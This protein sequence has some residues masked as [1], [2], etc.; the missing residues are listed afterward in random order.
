MRRGFEDRAHGVEL[1]GEG[2][3][4]L[5]A[6]GDLDL[7]VVDE[8]CDLV[9]GR[10]A[11]GATPDREELDDLFAGQA[12][13]PC[14]CDEEELG[15]G[16]VVVLAVARAG[17]GGLGE[18]ADPLVVADRRDRYTNRVGE[19]GDAH[20]PTVNLV[21]GFKVKPLTLNPGAG[22]T[23][24]PRTETRSRPRRS[25]CEPPARPFPWATSTS[26][27]PSSAKAHRSSSYTAPL[28]WAAPTCGRSTLG[29]MNFSSST[30]TSAAAGTLRWATCSACRSPVGSRTSRDCVKTLAW[31]ASRCS[32]TRPVATWLRCTPPSTPQRQRAWS[33]STRDRR[34]R[35]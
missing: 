11:V 5:D 12:Q 3:E 31:G 9:V 34:C 20:L 33:F 4:L 13:L 30:T 29:A 32:G 15:R 1:R 27:A 22:P 10:D 18:E 25:P 8:P 28:G 35:C 26:P 19:L 2:C 21:L 16:V 14:P 6:E 23:V 7:L 17:A 24:S